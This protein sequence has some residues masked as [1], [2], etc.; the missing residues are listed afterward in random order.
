MHRNL[1]LFELGAAEVVSLTTRWLQVGGCLAVLGLG[2]RAQALPQQ[3]S[4]A[5]SSA[6]MSALETSAI[7]APAH[8]TTNL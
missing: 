3:P 5:A 8:S 6:G 2:Q 7:A 4:L 1:S